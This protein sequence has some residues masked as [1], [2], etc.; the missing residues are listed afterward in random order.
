M[1]IVC[2]SLLFILLHIMRVSLLVQQQKEPS[3]KQVT[4]NQLGAVNRHNP[5]ALANGVS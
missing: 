5:D 3:G 4:L 2:G 1:R